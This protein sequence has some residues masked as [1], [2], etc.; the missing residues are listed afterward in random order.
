[1]DLE[2]EG[3]LFRAAVDGPAYDAISSAMT[4]AFGKP[5]TSLGKAARSR[6]AMCSPR[7]TLLRS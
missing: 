6:C 4:D 5:M 2:A 3:A 1:M 7:P